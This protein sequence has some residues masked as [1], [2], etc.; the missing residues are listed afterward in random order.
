MIN[1]ERHVGLNGLVALVREAEQAAEAFTCERNGHAWESDGGRVC[2][3]GCAWSQN[4]YRCRRC[5]AWDYGYI[6]G[7]GHEDCYGSG[8]CCDGSSEADNRA[9]AFESDH[10]RIIPGNDDLRNAGAT[11]VNT[12]QRY[13]RYRVTE[14][15]GSSPS[16]EIWWQVCDTHS[17]EQPAL[18]PEIY[19]NEDEATAAAKVLNAR[20]V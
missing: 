12:E 9:V 5:G 20:T 17:P 3:R 14:Q 7:P 1:S 18:L 15:R 8:H 4:A 13:Q 10:E 11:Q 19:R 2:P 16:L 6:G